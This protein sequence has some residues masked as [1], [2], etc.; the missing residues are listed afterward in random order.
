MGDFLLGPFSTAVVH[1]LLQIHTHTHTHPH[2]HTH[3][4]THMSRTKQ[5]LFQNADLEQQKNPVVVRISKE[6]KDL[7]GT[8]AFNDMLVKIVELYQL[9][10]NMII[11]SPQKPT[12]QSSQYRRAKKSIPRFSKTSSSWSNHPV[13]PSRPERPPSNSHRHFS[14]STIE[15]QHQEQIPS[16]TSAKKKQNCGFIHFYMQTNFKTLQNMNGVLFL[17][18]GAMTGTFF[19]KRQ[20]RICAKRFMLES[21]NDAAID[22]EGELLFLQGV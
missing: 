18:N 4:H 16:Q 21:M 22:F 20:I 19:S 11:H 2:T 8:S 9:S 7:K 17:R 5:H 1:I 6:C 3:A 13:Q 10:T 15:R 12:P 14:N